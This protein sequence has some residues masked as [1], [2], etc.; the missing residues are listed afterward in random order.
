MS[1]D[2]FIID[3]KAIGAIADIEPELEQE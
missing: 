1:A 2:G 3:R